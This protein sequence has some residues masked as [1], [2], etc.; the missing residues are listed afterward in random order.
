MLQCLSVFRLGELSEARARAWGRSH[1]KN[2]PSLQDNEDEHIL[3]TGRKRIVD[4]EIRMNKGL[5][6]VD[7]RQNPKDDAGGH[8][9]FMGLEDPAN[10]YQANGK[11]GGDAVVKMIE[12]EE[13][14]KWRD[15]SNHN[16]MLKN[17]VKIDLRG[18]HS[19]DRHLYSAGADGLFACISDQKTRIPPEQVNDDFC[20]CPDASDEPGTSACPS[21]SFYCTAQVPGMP[22]Q[23]IS[24]SKVNDGICD[25]CD[26]SDEWAGVLLP[27]FIR[28]KEGEKL[29]AVYHAPCSDKC[30]A[31]VEIQRKKQLTRERGQQL[32]R[33]YIR[34][35]VR[36]L[37]QS[38]QRK[39]YGPEGVFYPLSKQC[40][41]LRDKSYTYQVCP[42]S[43]VE[44][45]PQQGSPTSLGRNARNIIVENGQFLLEMVDGDT[46]LCPFGRARKSKIYM[47]CDVEEILLK[48]TESELC[49]YTFTL[50]T[51]AAC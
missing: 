18:V 43:K 12:N 24:S 41:T 6:E 44:Q 8:L 48:V 39:I 34:K 45:K 13:V 16:K 5:D 26:G 30:R 31:I 3:L 46:K 27:D 17:N 2:S 1:H 35:A 32:Q 9:K 29:G 7:L 38:A 42:F 36:D 11:V 19:K 50:S 20:D 10:V 21:G 47:S 14:E 25:C 15:N 40:F 22:P 23:S 4:G 28:I 33:D 51:P 49:E 37:P